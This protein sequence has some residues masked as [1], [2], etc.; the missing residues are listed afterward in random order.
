MLN[1]YV[2]V[3]SGEP[4]GPPLASSPSFAYKYFHLES[5]QAILR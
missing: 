4:G 1:K 5:V 3:G 2:H